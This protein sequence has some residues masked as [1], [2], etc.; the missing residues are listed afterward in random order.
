MCFNLCIVQCHFPT[1]LFEMNMYVRCGQ[2]L[3][4]LYHS[5]AVQKFLNCMPAK[6]LMAE[7]AIYQPGCLRNV[8]SLRQIHAFAIFQNPCSSF[9]F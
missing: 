1:Y 9:K 7:K 6:D 8:S 5:V 4:N 2:G 3:S